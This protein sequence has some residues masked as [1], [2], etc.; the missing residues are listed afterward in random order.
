MHKLRQLALSCLPEGTCLRTSR[1]GGLYA[2]YN[3]CLDDRLTQAG[4][5]AHKEG[6]WL[7]IGLTPALLPFIKKNLPPPRHDFF[8]AQLERLSGREISPEEI[9]LLEEALRGREPGGQADP[10]LEKR[11]RQLAALCL[12]RREGGGALSLIRQIYSETGG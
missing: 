12:R 2:A 9:T 8:L 3:A 11:L 7:I 6:D 5:R 4:F 1:R 10:H